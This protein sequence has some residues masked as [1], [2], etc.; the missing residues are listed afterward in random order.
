MVVAAVVLTMVVT[1]GVAMV[2][3]TVGSLVLT[4]TDASP[5]GR[6]LRWCGGWRSVLE[7]AFQFGWEESAMDAFQS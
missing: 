7:L 6:A 1:V 4:I 2:V 3:V 5:A